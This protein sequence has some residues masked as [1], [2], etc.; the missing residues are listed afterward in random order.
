MTK[1]FRTYLALSFL[2]TVSVSS[3]AA[4][5]PTGTTPG[6]P[7]VT[8]RV[9]NYAEVSL[10]TLERGQ[11]AAE[12]IFRQAD[13]EIVWVDCPLVK[14]LENPACKG[15]LSANEIALR[16][17]RRP[18]GVRVGFES[19]TGGVAVRNGEDTGSGY[20]S[21]YYDRVE[22]MTHCLN[23][24]WG[25]ILGHAAGHEIGHLLLRA[26]GHSREGIM[27]GKWGPK[28]WQLAGKGSLLF[29]RE[30]AELIRA[31]VLMRRK[32]QGPAQ[33]ANLRGQE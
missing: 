4:T 19:N 7:Q 16:I 2:L 24:S 12:K 33:I 30:Q 21:L 25:L 20:I 31:G 22:E 17:L 11:K 15:P 28:D 32:Q 1:T 10:E 3:S 29:T 8:V 6:I 26:G 9:Y 27:G 5:P 23:L 18:K 13:V 14:T